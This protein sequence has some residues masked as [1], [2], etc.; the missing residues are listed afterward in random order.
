VLLYGAFLALGF[1][2]FVIAYEEPALARQF[3]E[4]FA[5]YRAVTPRWWPRWRRG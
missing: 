5:R 3:G 2:V 4:S 1:H